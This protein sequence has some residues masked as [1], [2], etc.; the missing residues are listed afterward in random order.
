MPRRYPRSEE[1]YD[2]LKHHVGPVSKAYPCDDSYIYAIKNG[3]A[4]DPYAQFRHLFQSAVIGK[5]PARIWLRDL[6]GILENVA[7]DPAISELRELLSEKIMKDADSTSKML[8][9]LQDN[10]LD[11][12][13]CQDI[14]DALEIEQ[15]V[16]DGIRK[17][18]EKRLAE[19]SGGIRA[20]ASSR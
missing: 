3:E 12:K 20:V 1:T 10:H 6:E 5:A 18:V 7:P 11:R 2:V 9:G 17:L 13:E 8:D 4:N 15:Q 16:Q 19:L 14:L